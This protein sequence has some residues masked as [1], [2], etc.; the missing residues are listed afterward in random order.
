MKICMKDKV[1]KTSK[2]NENMYIFVL[3]KL[4][5]EFKEDKLLFKKKKS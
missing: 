1:M 4:Q 5:I 3:Y 2:S